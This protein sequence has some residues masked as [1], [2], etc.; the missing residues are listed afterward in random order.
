MAPQLSRFEF[1]LC[2]LRLVCGDCHVALCAAALPYAGVCTLS[3]KSYIRLVCT[4]LFRT[5]HKAIFDPSSDDCNLDLSFDIDDSS[6]CVNMTHLDFE[7]TN[8]TFTRTSDDKFKLM[9][10]GWS[11]FTFDL[12]SHSD[13]AAITSVAKLEMLRW[14]ANVTDTLTFHN[15]AMDVG[16]GGA[17]SYCT[18]NFYCQPCSPGSYHNQDSPDAFECQLW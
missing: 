6:E 10:N 18:E 1:L 5:I 13:A 7:T 2:A 16:Y 11:A 4:S 15:I 3:V 17:I 14:A 8:F 9:V 12:T